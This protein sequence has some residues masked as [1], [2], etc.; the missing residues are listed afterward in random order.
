MISTIHGT[1]WFYEDG[2]VHLYSL[3]SYISDVHSDYSVTIAARII[4]NTDGS[5]S[6]GKSFVYTE[7]SIY[8]TRSL[9]F[10]VEFNFGSAQA[11]YYIGEF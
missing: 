9:A 1:V 5:V 10:I 11:A 2:K 6:R 7:S 4:E 8:P 3:G